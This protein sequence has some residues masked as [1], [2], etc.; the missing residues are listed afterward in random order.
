MSRLDVENT[1]GML[2]K[3][4]K[5]IFHTELNLQ[6]GSQEV[7][8]FFYIL[9]EH[10]LG[11]EKFVLSFQPYL[12]INKEEETPLFDA[13]SKLKLNVPVQYIIGQAEFM[14]LTFKVNTHVLIPRPETED[15]VRWILDDYKKLTTTETKPISILDIGTGC[16]CIPISL[17]KNLEYSQ[18]KALDISVDA[19]EVAKANALSN[20]VEVDFYQGNILTGMPELRLPSNFDIIVSNPPYVRQLEKKEMHANVLE[21]EPETA[22]FVS[23]ED[24]LVFYRAIAKF[25]EKHLAVDGCLYLE[26]NQY[27]AAELLE[28][29]KSFDFKQIELRKDIFGNDRMVKVSR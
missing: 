3:E 18:V 24:P 25:A 29:L 12:V 8:S 23:D 27:L 15:L 11:L 5:T 1:L 19:L 17:V 13:L 26:I 10:F 6:Y 2:L 20:G 21:H 7:S 28:L 4:I 22:L 9:I 14:D 16:G